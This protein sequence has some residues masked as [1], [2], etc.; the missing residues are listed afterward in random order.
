MA[1]KSQSSDD[2]SLAQRWVS[3]SLTESESFYRNLF[4]VATAIVLLI[5]LFPFYYMIVVALT[6]NG[7]TTEAGLLPAGFDPSSFVEIF[8][9]IP[10]HR[11]IFNSLFIASS[12]TVFVLFVGSF[13]GYVFGRMEFRG[14]QPL[15]LAIVAISYFPGA[16][17]LVGLFKLLT[18]NVTVMGISSPNLFNTPAAAGLP[19]TSLALPFAVLL[20]TTFYSQIPDGL[21]DAAR[22]TGSTRIGALYR[23]IAPLSAPGLVTAGVLTFITAYNEFFFSQLMTTG[24]AEDWSPLVWGLTSYQSQVAIRYDLMAAASLVGVIPVA[25]L[26]LF[27]QRRIVSGLSSGSLKG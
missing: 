7:R 4:R 25:L 19:I 14:R 23:V 21:E 26:V 20:L 12:V 9:V 16:T 1:T 6:P 24:A 15:F 13:A 3:Y 22:V 27:A 2:G 11:F 18:G 10:L 8:Q 5:A 17:F